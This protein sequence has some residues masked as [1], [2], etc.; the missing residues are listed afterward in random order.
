MLP[1]SSILKI[2]VNGL[3]RI[4]SIPELLIF[5][6]TLDSTQIICAIQ[7]NNRFIFD[8]NIFESRWSSFRLIRRRSSSLSLSP[9]CLFCPHFLTFGTREC[10]FC[11]K[12]P[13]IIESC[14]RRLIQ[15]V[16]AF[17]PL[18]IFVFGCLKHV[19]VTASI[20]K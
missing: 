16:I 12:Y 14:K 4:N 6:P 9:I 15:K 20:C 19:R 5:T 3:R 18:L 17:D 10:I 11:R 2:S 8:Q 1:L 13:F 7:S